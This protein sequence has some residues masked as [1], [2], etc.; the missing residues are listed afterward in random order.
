MK[1][2]PIISLIVLIACCFVSGQTEIVC[3]E[4]SVVGPSVLTLPGETMA[5]TAEVKNLSGLEEIKYDWTVSAGTIEKGRG[6]S[7]IE[8]RT[9]GEMA[10]SNVTATVVI[11]GVPK[12]C[13][14]TASEIASVIS[15]PIVCYFPYTIRRSSSR[16]NFFLIDNSLI[17]MMNS[18]ELHQ[19]ITV[20][21]NE[22]ESR[23][24]K[25][26]FLNRIYNYLVYR[27][28]PLSRVTFVISKGADETEA[29]LLAV[30]PTLVTSM[31]QNG[32]VIKGTEYRQKINDI[33]KPKT[34][35]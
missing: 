28:F 21:L 5:F 20:R 19:L 1:R 34:I 12:D 14:Q 8:V 25:L 29:D 7:S 6:T 15:P 35:K 23:R 31:T 10:D 24:L 26:A 30:P 22:R 11:R 33:F 3:P 32:I 4:I 9:T 27:K 16:D 17:Q 13:K 2:V 18:P